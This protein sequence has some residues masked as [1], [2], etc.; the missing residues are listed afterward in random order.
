MRFL[1]SDSFT[2]SI[3]SLDVQNQGIVKQA[4]FDFQINP[5]HPSFQLHRI[6]R[7]KEK[8]FWSFRVNRDIRIIVYKDG[9]NLMLCFAGHHDE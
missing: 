2:N 8:H 9:K 1:I 6:E 4:A 7:S 5:E 3:Q